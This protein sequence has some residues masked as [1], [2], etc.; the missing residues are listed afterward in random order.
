MLACA[1]LAVLAMASCDRSASSGAHSVKAATEAVGDFKPSG[2]TKR[3]AQFIAQKT[4]E[5]SRRMMQ[6]EQDPDAQ[7]TI[8]KMIRVA[9]DHYRDLQRGEE[10]QQELQAATEA[11]IENLATELGK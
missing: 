4:I 5:Q 8:D 2:D 1:V 3:D 7:A 10:F 9:N 6:G 11:A